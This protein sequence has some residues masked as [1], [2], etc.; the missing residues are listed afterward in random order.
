ME[1][2]AY[3]IYKYAD[4]TV[5]NINYI[6]DISDISSSCTL[7]DKYQYVQSPS[8]NFNITQWT[9][10]YKDKEI[11][12]WVSSLDKIDSFYFYKHPEFEIKPVYG[13]DL[14]NYCGNVIQPIPRKRVGGLHIITHRTRQSLNHCSPNEEKARQLLQ[15]LIGF[16]RFVKYIRDGFVSF[17]GR[18][19]KIYQIHSG[20]KFTTVW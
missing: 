2:L 4:S 3:L 7:E 16:R 14:V 5:N 9:N 17:R 18:S 20:D 11:K 1:V 8:G 10:S 6:S 12:Q 15:R 13:S 19:G